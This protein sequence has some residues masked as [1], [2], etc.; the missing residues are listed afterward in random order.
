VTLIIAS[1]TYYIVHR[2]LVPKF[3]LSRRR[4]FEVEVIIALVL[5]LTWNV[6]LTIVSKESS[7]LFPYY[8]IG[9]V[10]PGILAHDMGRQGIEKTLLSTIIGILLVAAIVAPLK[11]FQ[12]VISQFLGESAQ[13]TS[14]LLRSQPYRYAYP[15]EL[16]PLAIVASVLINLLVFAR[17]RVRIGGY[18]TVAYLALFAVRPIDLVFVV[19]AS[20]LTYLFVTKFISQYMI[21]FGRTKFA[22]IILAGVVISWAMEVAL[23]E[24]SIGYYVPWSGF[25]VIMPMIVSL[26]A[27]DFDRQGVTR[28][29]VAVTA[30]GACVFL[31]M[32][33]ITQLLQVFDINLSQAAMEVINV[34]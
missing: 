28:T 30:A 2:F 27:S 5:Q 25:V 7:N 15:K 18:V 33:G 1:L 12:D 24:L 9:Y 34:I 14:P 17:Y 13:F 29:M 26:M 23:V 19:A 20:V 10:L 21:L 22:V 3:L 31:V 8:G 16:L 6:F 11:A 4:L 32:I